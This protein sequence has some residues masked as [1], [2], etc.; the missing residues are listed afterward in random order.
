MF[1]GVKM[2]ANKELICTDIWLWMLVNKLKNVPIIQ[3]RVQIKTKSGAIIHMLAKALEMQESHDDTALYLVTAT[4]KI[5]I[6]ELGIDEMTEI[7]D[8]LINNQPK[9][10]IGSDFYNYF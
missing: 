1:C 6:N 9:F 3:R 4:D 7:K 10:L 8:K 2:K 5:N